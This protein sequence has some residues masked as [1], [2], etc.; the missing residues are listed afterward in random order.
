MLKR[1]MLVGLCLTFLTM[2]SLAFAE[3]VYVTKKGK[4]Y[5]Q[6]TCGLIQKRDVVAIDKEEAIEKG[7]TPCS[8]CFKD[9]V[10]KD[11]VKDADETKAKE[12]E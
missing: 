10:S 3:D 2:S 9:E 5:H 12:K 7:Y 6:K 4:K 8:K 1:M 11:D